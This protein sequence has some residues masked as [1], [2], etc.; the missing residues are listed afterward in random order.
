M[1]KIFVLAFKI[2]SKKVTE[3]SSKTV[4]KISTVGPPNTVRFL[5]SI[6]VSDHSTE[7][8]PRCSRAI[9]LYRG[10]AQLWQEG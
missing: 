9:L 3:L 1:K 6:D 2:R 10:T 7:K 5:K 4:K 8:V